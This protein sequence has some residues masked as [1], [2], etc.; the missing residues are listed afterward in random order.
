MRTVKELIATIDLNDLEL[1]DN[2]RRLLRKALSNGLAKLF[3]KVG[4]VV[5]GHA[6]IRGVQVFTPE[7]QSK[8]AVA[9]GYIELY[10]TILSMLQDELNQIK[11]ESKS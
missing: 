11:G 6:D 9:Q 5:D 1:D 8:I 3:C 10:E 4:A 2:E 7:G